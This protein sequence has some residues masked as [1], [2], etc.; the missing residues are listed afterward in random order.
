MKIVV[1]GSGVAGL[2]CALSLI[3]FGHSVVIVTKSQ[4]A[5]SATWY[6]QGGV[7][8]A[9][10]PDDSVKSH[11]ADTLQAGAG[12]CD[13]QAVEVLVESGASAVEKLISRGA[14]FDTLSDGSFARTRE[15]GHHNNRI[16]HAGG[17]ATGEEIERSLVKAASNVNFD[18]LE[19]IDY[20]MVTKLL[21]N[22]RSCV[23][24]E[25]LDPAGELF[26]IEADH[27]VLATGGA[28]QLFSVTTNPV[29]ATA[30][31]VALALNANVVCADLEFMQFHP[32]ALHIDHM[33]RPL[34]SEALR[35]EGAVL[36][37]KNGKAFMSGLHD[38]ADLAPRDVVSKQIA[39][40]QLEQNVDHV[41]LDAT[42]IDKF[43]TRFP[44][45]FSSC[46]NAG[47]D[48][49]KDL[50]PVSPAAH[51]FC[52]GIATDTYGSTSLKGLWAAGEVS[53]NGVHGANRLASN[54]LLEGLV[55]GERVASS[56]ND[57]FNGF[58]R[59]GIF[60]DYDEWPESLKDSSN[61]IDESEFDLPTDKV[62]ELRLKLQRLMTK[63]V[64]V[65]R[66][67]ESLGLASKLIEEEIIS[68]SRVV[69]S[70]KSS[71]F[72]NI[73]LR[74]LVRV[75]QAVVMNAS[76]RQESRGC[77]SRT[78]FSG[79]NQKYLGRFFLNGEINESKFVA[80]KE[81]SY[82]G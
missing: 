81:K 11:I 8:S 36:I 70:A 9:M 28:G 20:S 19:V 14:H 31:G 59:T 6:A 44:N 71:D 48:P 1:V 2:T 43:S 65:L 79:T 37:D 17:D 7:A 25:Y 38:M 30:D 67:S 80:S 21:V 52:G 57:G 15:G 64:G 60:I 10:F 74:H 12:L 33:P 72:A 39:K 16:I 55:F 77:H 78:D 54:S 46:M 82:L 41:Y 63:N 18:A 50:L 47:I 23:G 26:S 51:Y 58:R 35:G 34:L 5:D 66:N 56:I 24:I 62:V 53:C 32:T 69:E 73:E 42:K 75:A 68:H 4:T 13:A 61:K 76:A 3:E 29:L 45:I 27:V 22:N 49:R 40:V